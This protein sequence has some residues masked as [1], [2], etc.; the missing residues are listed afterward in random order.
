MP[1]YENTY[2]RVTAI[3]YLFIFTDSVCSDI[4]KIV[5]LKGYKLGIS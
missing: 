4:L 3:D 5:L 1:F 2:L